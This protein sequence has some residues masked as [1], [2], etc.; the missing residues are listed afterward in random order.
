MTIEQFVLY[1]VAIFAVSIIPGPS[2]AL[3]FAEGTKGGV[4]GSLPA[5]LGN[6]A[7]SLGQGLIAFL[8]FQSIVSLDPQILQV[9]QTVGA[10]YIGYIGFV[11]LR[12][13]SRFHIETKQVERTPSMLVAKFQVGFW[14]AFF[15]PKAILFFAALFPQFVNSSVG[16]NI[17]AI[18]AVFVPIA[19]IA[20][21]C[22]LA[23]GYLGQISLRI[24]E[25]SRPARAIIPGLGACLVVMAV[26]GLYDGLTQILG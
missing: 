14:V 3:A 9:V 20:L 5:A 2:M 11:F 25:R 17:G 6:V 13:G 19:F 12:D 1:C 22:F 16:T 4:S 18:G 26:L 15:N 21:I 23:Y 10:V 7:A 8:I 24:F